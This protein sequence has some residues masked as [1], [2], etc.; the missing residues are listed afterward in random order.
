MLADRFSYLLYENKHNE[1]N[2]KTQI[3]VGYDNI[4]LKEKDGDF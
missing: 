4:Q 2:T 1:W 3:G